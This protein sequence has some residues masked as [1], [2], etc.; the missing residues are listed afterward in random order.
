MTLPCQHQESIVRQ[1]QPTVELL[2]NLDIWY[3]AILRQHQIEPA[4]YKRGLVFRSAVESIRGSFIASSKTGRE[5]LVGDVLENLKQQKHIVDYECTSGNARYDFTVV[6]EEEPEIYAAVEVKGGEG[7]SINISDRPRWARE[8]VVWCHLDGAITNQPSHGARAIIGRLTNELVRRR[9][10]VDALIFKDILCGTSTR[11]CPKYPGRE[12]SI[13]LLAAPDVFLF[14][15]RIPTPKDP[16][17]PIH[18]LEDLALPK[19]ILA[20]FGV[21]VMEYPRHLWEVYVRIEKVDDLRVRREVEVW[22]QGQL[23]ERIKGWP[24]KWRVDR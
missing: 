3:P 17:P 12:D 7:N 10:R 24:W 1:I 14:P 8:F 23:V 9:K 5:G 20:L 6:L 4:D 11:P 19:K 22:H 15:S 13:G 2:S 21:N 16:S 18:S